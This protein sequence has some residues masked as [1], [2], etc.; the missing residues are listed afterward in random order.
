MKTARTVQRS[1]CVRVSARA[2]RGESTPVQF[3]I[4]GRHVEVTESLDQHVREKL[5]V[6]LDKF[7]GAEYLEGEGGLRDV[8][9]KLMNSQVELR[10]RPRVQIKQTNDTFLRQGELKVLEFGD[11]VYDSLDKAVATL[12]RK[13]KKY[14][15][16][17]PLMKDYRQF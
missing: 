15:K 5:Q 14:T 7:K 2:T 6:A 8:D 10:L 16:A 13:L 17:A 1:L 12:E 4:H 3:N 11:D 9:V